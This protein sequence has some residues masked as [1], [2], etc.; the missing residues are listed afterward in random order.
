MSF[1]V[2]DGCLEFLA[3]QC[4]PVSYALL[5]ASVLAENQIPELDVASKAA[6]WA[7]LCQ[8]RDVL[9]LV[10]NADPTM[11]AKSS[12]LCQL[13][14]AP[15][16]T[17]PT[18]SPADSGGAPETASGS[19]D[20]S[21]MQFIDASRLWCSNALRM[22]KLNLLFCEHILKSPERFRILMAIASR[23]YNGYWQHEL[24]NDLGI[25]PRDL[26]SHTVHMVK[27]AQL[28]RVSIPQDCVSK[29]LVREK[30]HNAKGRRGSKGCDADAG[31]GSHGGSQ[32]AT[33]WFH[34]RYFVLD[35]LPELVQELCFNRPSEAMGERLLKV[36]YER[37]NRIM[38][39][40]DFKDAYSSILLE[41]ISGVQP[42]VDNRMITKS[43][44]SLRRS[45]EL[46]RKISRAFAWCPQTNRFERCII[47]YSDAAEASESHSAPTSQT[48][49]VRVINL[50][51]RQATAGSK[52][53]DDSGLAPTPL[54]YQLPY[55]MHGHTLA[56]C[57]YYLVR[58]RRGSIGVND[59]NNHLCM[60]YKLLTKI[61]T[62]LEGGVVVKKPVRDGKMLM[63][64]YSVPN[65]DAPE[66]IA[67]LPPAAESAAPQPARAA[68]SKGAKGAAG[69]PAAVPAD[70]DSDPTR[71]TGVPREASG[72]SDAAGGCD[73]YSVELR[74]LLQTPIVPSSYGPSDSGGHAASPRTAPANDASNMDACS[75][76][77]NDWVVK[78]RALYPNDESYDGRFK[79]LFGSDVSLPKSINT[80]AFRRRMVLLC[81]YIECF[82]A[83]SCNV[84]AAMYADVEAESDKRVDRKT[85]KRLAT[86]VAGLR[87][88]IAMINGQDLTGV[89][90]SITVIYDSR[91]LTDYGAFK[92]V[93]DGI[94]KKRQLVSSHAATLQKR[95][96]TSFKGPDDV[97]EIAVPAGAP[98]SAL[99]GLLSVESATLL[100]NVE[101]NKQQ[102][103]KK[104]SENVVSFSQRELSNNGYIFPVVTRVKHLHRF[105]L[106]FGAAGGRFSAA[107][108][109]ERLP[110]DLFLQVIGCGYA[111]RNVFDLLEGNVLPVHVEDGVF[112]AIYDTHGR[113]S[114]VHLMHRMLSLL[115]TLGL[116]RAHHC[117]LDPASKA[118][119]SRT[120]VE[121]EVC[122]CV[123]LH[124][125]TE[126]SRVVGRFEMPG[127]CERFWQT[128]QAE[129][130]A[131]LSL[132]RD[133]PPESLPV[134]ELF[135]K[136][137]WKRSFY[138]GNFCRNQLDRSISTWFRLTCN[139]IDY[140]QLLRFLY[141]PR[142]LVDLFSQR[143]NISH[144]NLL[145]YISHRV[146][147]I[148]SPCADAGVHS[149]VVS[150][151]KNMG[152][153]LEYLWLAKFVLAE[154]LCNASFSER[155]TSLRDSF[156]DTPI[157]WGSLRSRLVAA[158]E[159]L[160]PR[161]KRRRV[162]EVGI[163]AQSALKQVAEDRATTQ[164]AP[165]SGDD[166]TA[167]AMTDVDMA[168][169][170][171]KVDTGVSGKEAGHQGRLSSESRLSE[172]SAWKHVDA[173]SG[174]S[175]SV[176]QIWSLLSILFDRRFSPA[177]CRYIFSTIMNESSMSLRVLRRFREMSAGD[178]MRCA[179]KCHIP[180][181]RV[182]T[183]RRTPFDHTK[184]CLKSLLFTPVVAMRSW[185]LDSAADFRRGRSLL[186]HW[187]DNG[188]V[189]R[190]KQTSN[191]Y[192]LY[193]LS[194]F[195]RVKLFGKFKDLRFM[196]KALASQLSLPLDGRGPA[197]ASES[198][199]ATPSGGTSERST[200]WEMDLGATRCGFML[201]SA[202][203]REV[204]M[205][206]GGARVASGNPSRFVRL[207]E[208]LALHDIYVLMERFVN[209]Q[210]SF[211]PVWRR[212]EFVDG[213]DAKR[214]KVSYDRL[215]DGGISRHIRELTPGIPSVAS[216]R[217]GITRD[218]RVSPTEAHA[219]AALAVHD[220]SA[221]PSRIITQEL[222]CG[223][224]FSDALNPIGCAAPAFTS[225]VNPGYPLCNF[226]YGSDGDKG[227]WTDRH[228]V[229]IP[230]PASS[231]GATH[232]DGGVTSSHGSHHGT[233][234][235]TE[236]VE[237]P[238]ATS[239]D[240]KSTDTLG[241]TASGAST[242][243][244]L[245]SVFLRVID[246]V[247]GEETLFLKQR[248]PDLEESL[249]DIVC[250][251]REAESGGV[252]E[253]DLRSHFFGGQ[254]HK[255]G[256][257]RLA[258]PGGYVGATEAAYDVVITVAEVLRLVTRRACGEEFIYI[259]W[260]YSGGAHAE[261]E[262][263]VGVRL[264]SKGQRG[265]D[266]GYPV[267]TALERPDYIPPLLWVLYEERVAAHIS[268]AALEV[269]IG[270]LAELIPVG[271]VRDRFVSHARKSPLGVF[272][273]LDG[274]LNRCVLAFL[275]LRVARL[276]RSVP[277]QTAVEVWE[278]I[279]ILDLCEVKLLLRGMISLGICRRTSP[280]SS[281]HRGPACAVDNPSQPHVHFISE[282]ALWLPKFRCV[283]L[284]FF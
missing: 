99:T 46:K 30:L 23:R 165:R 260:D 37:E 31:E 266:R 252:A 155:M 200:L 194:T 44:M 14:E 33:L 71:S 223:S 201:A 222:V 151:A 159:A 90:F 53:A 169:A 70:A 241:A 233:P 138:V 251:V 134:N 115:R 18:V 54:L 122:R 213:R 92:V 41:D 247:M 80:A 268:S 236:A 107:Q 166:T 91:Q 261:V 164:G 121:W 67:G 106:D 253:S 20:A 79:V 142:Y 81:D 207:S 55:Q 161:T 156:V 228:F 10:D 7:K 2:F 75:F 273:S 245:R 231:D 101:V 103:A 205:A 239:T 63:Y 202:A 157:T 221:T 102:A 32:L 215:N 85:V 76:Q 9:V 226:E 84:V 105:L 250:V 185:F 52:E 109:L 193:K 237:A 111:L 189:V 270:R 127:S 269:S 133:A 3:S 190:T 19:Y 148:G 186:R 140:R 144:E 139:G 187:S 208:D 4:E 118:S 77:Y 96:N 95:I 120:A 168:N 29:Q 196:A 60:P 16:G 50:L 128:L 42:H 56:E 89:S 216:T 267:K 86:V 83:A 65:L 218:A 191:V 278:K 45:L 48:R 143:H 68:K 126:P 176:N 104:P 192:T 131:Y 225:R 254:G 235:G 280:L 256:E 94:N 62:S 21:L 64:V 49:A 255:Y 5:L 229:S 172:L 175:H 119:V 217:V 199:E 57:A 136:K 78:Q 15:Q 227:W 12:R 123:T 171:V 114:P 271:N 22:R 125:L 262:P 275:M 88:H 188:W 116:V 141:M 149:S 203:A 146:R 129:V 51:P 230:L 110:M 219:S 224:R 124:G 47:P 211:G 11:I 283:L 26:F 59:L 181:Y 17:D 147:T 112:D 242:P 153:E 163:S 137:N 35:R 178:I 180:T 13:R 152:T 74:E 130:D 24:V 182:L 73:L 98:L 272:V 38:L 150:Y 184:C 214:A 183:N 240:A 173:G 257:R 39:D 154:R 244:T 145:S 281:L 243:T 170:G 212:E 174:Q 66:P 204:G 34:P 177:E 135:R 158:A 36:L 162:A 284:P 259:Y 238:G 167:F 8:D 220:R 27:V 87:P 234:S 279:V 198:S 72:A 179:Q 100:K 108:V 195:A 282:E 263:I 210:L 249:Y 61:M 69:R 6:L 248:L 58:C 132:D 274:H 197:L 206:E 246:V 43:F 97:T 117:P 160:P 28:C 265:S 113:R 93:I 264:Y 258:T 276:L 82:Q 25:S 40:S 277:G 232:P 1:D 209:G